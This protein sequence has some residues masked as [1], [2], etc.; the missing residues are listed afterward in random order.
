MRQL[1]VVLLLAP[2]VLAGC[3]GWHDLFGSK[4][5]AASQPLNCSRAPLEVIIARAGM[6]CGD[7]NACPS[8]SYCNTSGVCSWACYTDS[9]CSTGQVCGCD[10]RCTGDTGSNPDGGPPTTNLS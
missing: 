10:G 8:G 3:G 9:E 7:S 6:A 4:T 2:L 5:S 1:K